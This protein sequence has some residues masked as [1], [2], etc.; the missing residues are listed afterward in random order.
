MQ[1]YLDR[2]GARDFLRERGIPIGENSL[3]DHAARG[4]G[5][6]YV[7][8]NGRALYTEADLLAWIEG[9]AS[10]PPSRSGRPRRAASQTAA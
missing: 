3:K 2:D 7:H 5:P 8:I 1:K 4:T 10:R 9:Q 6:H